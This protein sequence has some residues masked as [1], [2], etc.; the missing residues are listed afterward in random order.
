[1]SGFSAFSEPDASKRMTLRRVCTLVLII[2]A[3]ILALYGLARA[4]APNI[5][6]SLEQQGL[7]AITIVTPRPPEPTPTPT[8]QPRPDEGAQGAPGRQAV[9]RPAEAPL[10]RLPIQPPIP[11]PQVASTGTANRSGAADAGEGTG[12][13]GVGSGTGSGFGGGGQGGRLAP[14]QPVKIAGDINS[15]ADYPTPSGGREIRRGRS[16]TIYLTVGP[17]GR[18]T[19]CRIASPSPDPEADRI[20]CELAVERFRFEPARNADGEP[21]TGTYGWRQRW[22]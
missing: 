16:V 9:A 7:E 12:A 11:I 18:A 13:A 2:L 5:V 21:V 8:P 1:M 20:T 15:S 17:D 3:H 6:A 22:F 19:G 10:V 4:L 14:T